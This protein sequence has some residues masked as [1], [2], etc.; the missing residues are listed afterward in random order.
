[1]EKKAENINE[2][3]VTEETILISPLCKY[4]DKVL[5][6]AHI[7]TFAEIDGVE[8]RFEGD[9]VLVLNKIK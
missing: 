6:N 3:E 5:C 8:Y 4:R 1:M 7:T 2:S 9:I